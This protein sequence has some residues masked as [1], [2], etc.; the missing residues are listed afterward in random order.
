MTPAE[1]QDLRMRLDGA[2]SRALVDRAYAADLLARPQ[3]NLG[4]QEVAGTYGTLREL[5]Q[6]MTKLFWP[7][8]SRL[9]PRS[10]SSGHR[11]R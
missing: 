8:S 2:I 3:E 1:E 11:Q 10:G 7:A 9:I 4:T 5:A 6:H